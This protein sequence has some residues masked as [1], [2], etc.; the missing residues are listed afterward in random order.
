VAYKG[1]DDNGGAK[2]MAEDA[3]EEYDNAVKAVQKAERDNASEYET[4]IAQCN[5]KIQKFQEEIQKLLKERID[6]P[7]NKSINSS[8]ETLNFWF[9]FLDSEGQVEQYSVRKI[10]SRAKV[11]NDNSI[12]AIYFRKTPEV[13]FTDSDSAE[14]QEHLGYRTI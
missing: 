4:F 6:H 7:W 13:I 9:D 14:S 1:E 5:E 11:I 3:Q 2:K 10:G 12:K 8:P